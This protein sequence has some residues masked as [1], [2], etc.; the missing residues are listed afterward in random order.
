MTITPRANIRKE[1][2]VYHE[3]FAEN[4]F[5]DLW[6]EKISNN[7]FCKIKFC[8]TLPNLPHPLTMRY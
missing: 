8:V 5:C 1:V 6:I 4:L 7:V 3:N 2:T